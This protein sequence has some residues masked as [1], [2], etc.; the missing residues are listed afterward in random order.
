[1]IHEKSKFALWAGFYTYFASTLLYAALTVGITNSIT[2]SIKRQ[3]GLKEW[4]I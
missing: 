4:Q 3:K 1:M 2:D